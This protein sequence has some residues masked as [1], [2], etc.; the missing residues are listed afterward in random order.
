MAKKREF[1]IHAIHIF[2]LFSFALVQP[3]LEITSRNAE[4]FVAHYS[5]PVDIILLLLLLCI[6]LPGLIIL[7]ETAKTKPSKGRYSNLLSCPFGDSG[8]LL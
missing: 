3:L 8:W 7:L 1:I 6:L 4:F 5:R 2:V